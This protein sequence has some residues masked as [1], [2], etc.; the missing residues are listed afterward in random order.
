MNFLKKLQTNK[1]VVIGNTLEF[2]DLYLYVHLA[3]IINEKFF[4]G[5]NAFFLRMFS[6]SSLYILAPISCIF[7][8][9]IGDLK[10]RKIVLV[11]AS[12]AMAMSSLLILFLPTYEYWGIYSSILLVMLRIIQGISLSGE[13]I[14]SSLYLVESTKNTRFYPMLGSI[15]VASEC[16][17]GACALGLGFIAM[18]YLSDYSW[19]WR[20]PFIFTLIFVFFS[21]KIRW[22]LKESPE[23][24]ESGYLNKKISVF[25][26]KEMMTFYGSCDFKK[27]NVVCYFFLMFTYPV[28]F[29]M[30]YLYLSPRVLEK[31]G[32]PKDGIMLYN[33]LLTLGQA[34]LLL[35]ISAFA[36][37][38]DYTI[39]TLKKITIARYILAICT[40]GCF[41]YVLNNCPNYYLLLGCQ[42]L[43]MG[44]PNFS[45]ISAYIS[46]SF[47]VIGRYTYTAIPWACA[48]ITNFFLVVFV[49]D[50]L[51]IH[52]GIVGTFTLSAL[53]ILCAIIAVY[54]STPYNRMKSEHMAISF[55][56]GTPV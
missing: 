29:A 12:I 7:L 44:L 1:L 56:S 18:H 15:L 49:L 4:P 8:A 33:L 6:F 26:K 53:L 35:L 54:C 3:T 17:G 14:A 30:S 51:N 11:G 50:L 13:P 46:K 25:N 5:G 10:G 55:K 38:K 24:I 39:E 32:E 20:L 40:F 28:L 31:L 21:L 47:A 23:Y 16:L 36:V 52:Y 45:L 37:W 42:I 48:R 41:Y 19:G 43:I 22:I 9:Y 27:R 34:A 2:F